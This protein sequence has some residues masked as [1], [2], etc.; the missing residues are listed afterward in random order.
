MSKVVLDASAL[1][2]LLNQEAGHE[3]VEKHLSNAVMSTVNISEVISV[4]IDTGIP[5]KTARE[6]VL[7]IIKE[8][9]PFELQHAFVTASMKKTT[10]A[11]GLSFGDRACLTLAELKKLPALTADKIWAKIDNPEIKI[12]L[13]R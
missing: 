7:E 12:I 10:K 5:H 9:I 4:L 6:M 2:A 8:I 3:L 13:I 1:L 11:Y